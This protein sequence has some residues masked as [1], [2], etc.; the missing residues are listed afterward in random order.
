MTSFGR[1]RGWSIQSQNPNKEQGLR[2]PGNA[3]CGNN[4]V[5]DIIDKIVT[6]D[7]HEHIS[8]QLIQEITDLLTSAV[9]KDSLKDTCDNLWKQAT[10]YDS[11]T[12]KIGVIFSDYKVALIEDNNKENIR[13][14]FLRLL[15]DNYMSREKYKMQDKKKFANIVLLHAEVFYHMRLSDG[16]KLKILAEPLIQYLE[17]LLQDN[18][19]ENIYFIMIQI[20]RSGKDLHAV[21]P[22]RL[23]NLMLIIRQMLVKENNYSSQ[24]R[25]MLLLMIELVNNKYEINDIQLKHFYLSN[26]KSLSF[27]YPFSQKELRVVAETKTENDNELREIDNNQRIIREEIKNDLSEQASYSKNPN[28]PRAIRGSGGLDMPRKGDNINTK[29]NSLKVTP[30]QKNNKGWDHDDRFHKDYE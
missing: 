15:Q 1:G 24:N 20:L 19:K 6:Y 30:R 4:F 9:N 22:D 2:R 14:R 7:V 28:I 3:T 26:I 13:S 10:L 11:L 12:A 5:K 8:P 29:L 17:D 27:E 23:E 18:V 21:C 16:G 25:A